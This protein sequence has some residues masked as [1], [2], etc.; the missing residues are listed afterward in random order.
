MSKYIIHHETKTIHYSS[1]VGD[2]CLLPCFDN[3]HREDSTDDDYI[4]T[5]I[6]KSYTTCQYC[7]DISYNTNT[8]LKIPLKHN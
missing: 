7:M 3:S 6:G 5:L 4:Q 1:F 2:D 8:E